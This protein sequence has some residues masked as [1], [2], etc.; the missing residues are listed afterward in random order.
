M[1]GAGQKAGQKLVV[2]VWFGSDRRD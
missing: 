2:S 1:P